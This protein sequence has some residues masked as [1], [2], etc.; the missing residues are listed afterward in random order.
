MNGREKKMGSGASRLVAPSEPASKANM[1]ITRFEI[2]QVAALQTFVP[3]SSRRSLCAPWS[4]QSSLLRVTTSAAWLGLLST[5]ASR[6]SPGTD[7]SRRTRW[8]L[9]RKG[10]K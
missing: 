3:F 7:V 10:S 8:S 6:P 4:P 5:S 2:G 1:P 9:R